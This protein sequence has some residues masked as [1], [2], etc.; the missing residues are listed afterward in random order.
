MTIIRILSVISKSSISLWR[1]MLAKAHSGT[2]LFIAD[3]SFNVMEENRKA[4][5]QWGWDYVEEIS[6]RIWS[7]DGMESRRKEVL[8][9]L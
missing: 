3:H 5:V 7:P 8:S 6:F 1:N 2:L 4:L 9:C